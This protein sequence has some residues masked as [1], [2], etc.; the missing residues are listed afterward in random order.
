MLAVAP[1]SLPGKGAIEGDAVDLFVERARAARPGFVPRDA[2]AP[3]VAEIVRK[4]DGIPL[5]IE[6]AAA[7]MG[8]LSAA[9]LLEKL[10]SRLDLLVTGRRD[11]S[12]RHQT[13]RAAIEW[14]WELLSPVE[15]AALEQASVFSGGFSLEAAR[16][17]LALEGAP[18]IQDVLQGLVEKSLLRAWS[19]EELPEE[20]R[21]AMF[22]SIRDFALE[23]LGPARREAESRHADFFLERGS[24]WSESVRRRDGAA[25]LAKLALEAENHISL[26]ERA[27]AAP[28][29]PESRER[30][31]RAILVL[32][33]LLSMQG[34]FVRLLQGID[35]ALQR[36]SGVDPLLVARVLRARGRACYRFGPSRLEAFPDLERAL[37]LARLAGDAALEARLQDD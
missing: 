8:V 10:P 18:E 22:E 30:A 26:H 4:L 36:L 3:V 24:A 17:V 34:P 21:F 12:S 9:Q 27:L 28:E 35:A 7:R 32:D 5:A 20:L 15:R 23:K 16:A 1:L 14:S 25:A 33:A 6:L 13:L 31:L 2:D 11:A 29:S 19:P 37:E